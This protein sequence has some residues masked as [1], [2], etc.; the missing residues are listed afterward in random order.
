M[1]NAY[2]KSS[3][4]GEQIESALLESKKI[5]EANE[6]AQVGQVLTKS[7]TGYV[8]NDILTLPYGSTVTYE[9]GTIGYAVNKEEYFSGTVGKTL[10][11]MSEQIDSLEEK[12]KTFYRDAQGYLCEY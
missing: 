2:Y 11:T 5:E 12:T 8:F 10:N 4:T 6:T 3:L 9:E 1:A 7:G